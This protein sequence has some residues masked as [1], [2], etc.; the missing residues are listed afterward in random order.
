MSRKVP[1]SLSVVQYDE[2][3]LV[4]KHEVK[5]CKQL[6]RRVLGEQLKIAHRTDTAL[7]AC[8][9][10]KVVGMAMLT[11]YSPELHFGETVSDADKADADGVYLYN[12][13]TDFYAY[14]GIGDVLMAQLGPHVNLDVA[15]GNDRALKFFR[16]HGFADV[17]EYK[18]REVTYRAMS[19]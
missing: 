7:I 15:E 11:Q 19:R 16:R 1:A 8:M 3:N 5:G 13:V 10:K 17:G 4:P 6:L 12:L 9:G 18:A 2:W 14:Q